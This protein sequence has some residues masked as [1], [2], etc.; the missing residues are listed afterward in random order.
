MSV[1]NETF[2]FA[3]GFCL[4]RQSNY[5]SSVKNRLG[6]ITGDRNKYVKR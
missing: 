6:N 1:Y 4:N 2:G 5:T 3:G